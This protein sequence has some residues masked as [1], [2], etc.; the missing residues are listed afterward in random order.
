[1]VFGQSQ[2]LHAQ[3][4]EL[5]FTTIRTDPISLDIDN[6]VFEPS[7][8]YTFSY[9]NLGVRAIYAWRST[10]RR[11]GSGTAYPANSNNQIH[12]GALG[13]QY[14]L[15]FQ[16]FEFYALTDLGYS[17]RDYAGSSS[18]AKLRKG[19]ASWG[20]VST[21]S[22]RP[23]IGL[24]YRLWKQLYLGCEFQQQLNWNHRIGSW[25]AYYYDP[26]P[27]I[28]RTLTDSGELDDKYFNSLSMLSGLVI[29]WRF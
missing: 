26:N 17:Q 29:S 5:G 13:L 25:E 20:E 3:Q 28:G 9:K 2:P 15:A 16:K 8:R 1:M 12:Y 18:D 23:G 10:K 27:S 19:A 7:L 11:L 14:A 6:R 21:I 4:H 24:K 22:L